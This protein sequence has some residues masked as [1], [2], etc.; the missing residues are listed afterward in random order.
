M[1]ALQLPI[2]ST[3]PNNTLDPNIV[4]LIAINI[5][6][7]QSLLNFSLINKS[8]YNQI[9]ND[10]SL[11]IMHLTTLGNWKKPSK[12][13]LTRT[14]RS[15]VSSSTG[16]TSSHQHHRRKSS[17]SRPA[18]T[19]NHKANSHSTEINP[20]QVQQL[21]II[22]DDADTSNLTPIN[23][24][25]KQI[26]D[27]HLARSQFIK[28]Y[29]IMS[30]IVSDMLIK[31]YANIQNLAVLKEFNNPSDQAMLFSNVLRFLSLY[32]YEP[33]FKT[34]I[35]RLNA[36]LDLFVN[37]LVREIDINL[38]NHDY[39]MVRSLI[40]SMDHLV[41]DTDEIQVDPLEALLE[42]F[43]NKYMESYTF[44]M[45]DDYINGDLFEKVEYFERGVVNGYKF[46][47]DQIDE[48]FDNKLLSLLNSQ[49][50]EI[51]SI[52][53]YPDAPKPTSDANTIDEVPIVLKV[54]ET[55][56][57]SH[58]I[59]GFVDKVIQRAKE[60]DSSEA[61]VTYL[62]RPKKGQPQKN[63]EIVNGEVENA[64]TQENV[65]ADTDIVGP[66]KEST[67]INTDLESKEAGAEDEDDEEPEASR[68]INI[69]NES[70]LFF[71]C[72]PY[73]HNKLAQTINLLNYYRVR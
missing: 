1:V 46:R 57:S 19:S 48:L 54:F 32:K 37:T 71:Q 16:P 15:T 23:C 60:I 12:K 53:H 21:L 34:M 65:W 5:S 61:E 50:S 44:M 41:I 6:N 45:T 7:F 40:S 49:L 11:W 25:E 51:N 55:F 39:A 22:D 52:F 29:G 14:R 42:L 2:P 28:I 64:P 38:D 69:M 70:S 43:I 10:E 27:P 8:C 18:S 67:A 59:G 72:V 56:L 24:L 63:Q 31:Q 66:K 4:H 35:I 17:V 3:K 26:S 30:P 13:Q 62:E 58:L 36:I 47:F 9:I 68:H 33:G 73:M 20:E